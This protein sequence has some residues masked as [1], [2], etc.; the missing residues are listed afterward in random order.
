M[1]LFCADSLLLACADVQAEKRWWIA[2]YSRQ[3]DH[4]VV[5]CINV[6]KAHEYLCVINAPPGPVQEVG[7]AKFFEI[8]DPE[9]NGI[10]ICE[11]P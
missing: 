3:N 9:G 11:A 10:E 2:R 7:G 4:P 8:R 6:K 5:F 1:A